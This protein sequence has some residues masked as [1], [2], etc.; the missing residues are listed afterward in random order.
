MI[1]RHWHYNR[2]NNEVVE[3]P[4]THQ[5]TT[6]SMLLRKS[7]CLMRSSTTYS[8]AMLLE[9]SANEPFE[10]VASGKVRI[11]VNQRFALEDAADADKA[12]EARATS[13]SAIPII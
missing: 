6:E 11:N 10:V 7:V 3:L 8:A 2:E 5:S 13:G 1:V 4:A 12:L 9:A